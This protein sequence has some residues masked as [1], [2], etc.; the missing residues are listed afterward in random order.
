LEVH[1]CD[2]ARREVPNPLDESIDRYLRSNKALE[3]GLEAVCISIPLR[4]A[5]VAFDSP[6]KGSAQSA[7]RAP[8]RADESVD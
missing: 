6:V 1:G 8:G 3:L 5:F 7:R 2:L 4:N